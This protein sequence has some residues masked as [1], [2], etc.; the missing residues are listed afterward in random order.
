VTVTAYEPDRRDAAAL[1]TELARAAS[2]SPMHGGAG[3]TW[4]D[5][6]FAAGALRDE[7]E[8]SQTLLRAVAEACAG[9]VDHLDELPTRA[10]R[11][12]LE[13]RLGITRLPIVPDRLV[14]VVTGDPK[15]LPV[16]LRK[17]SRLK[18]GKGPLGD[19]IY[20]TVEDLVVIGTPVV[21]AHTYRVHDTGEDVV[22]R[23]D[24]PLGDAGPAD[25]LGPESESAATHELIVASDLLRLDTGT[26]TITL[27][28]AGIRFERAMPS[29]TTVTRAFL[30][31]LRWEL[32]GAGGYSALGVSSVTALG[33]DGARVLL[34]ATVPS[35]PAPVGSVDRYH[36]RARFP[37][38]AS[39]GFSA[40]QA[41]GFSFTGLSLQMSGS[42]VQPQAGYANEGLL[43][44]TKEFKP[45]GPVPQRGD[46]F[47]LRS[48]E[49]FSK[50]LSS[51]TVTLEAFTTGG[52]FQEVAFL[53]LQDEQLRMVYRQANEY[54]R[55]EGSDV[56]LDESILDS[57]SVDPPKIRWDQYSGGEWHEFKR[58]D[59]LAT[60]TATIGG[61]G[62]F[63][64]PTTVGGAE[65]RLI[66][67]FLWNGDFGWQ[68]YVETLATNAQLAASGH[69]DQIDTS[70]PLVP[71]APP[72][73]SRVRLGY[74]TALRSM[75][76]NPQEVRVF[77]RNALAEPADVTA[78]AT[79]APFQAGPANSSTLYV[80]LD[81]ALPLGEI[82]SLYLDIDA[83]HAC[84]PRDL[85]T[86]VTFEYDAAAGGWTGLDLFDGTLGL[87][88]SGV[89]RFVS[90][91]DWA[92]GSGTVTAAH[93]RWLRARATS[94]NVPER[95]LR[96]Q[97]DAVEAVYRLVPGH[98]Q[99]DA[100]SATP[101]PADAVTGLA[102]AVPGIK[103]MTN[104]KPSYAGRGPELDLAFFARASGIPRHRNK[105]VTAWDVEELVR[106]NFPDVALV[107]CLAHHSAMSEC[108]RGAISIVAVPRS[109]ERLPVPTVQLASSIKSFV[110]ERATP[111]LAP[112]VLCPIYAEVSVRTTLKLVPGAPG[113]DARRLL[114]QA[115]RDFLH[116]LRTTRRKRGFGES[117]YRSELIRFLEGHPLVL[118]VKDG[119]LDFEP[120]HNGLER[121]DVDACRGLIASAA[122]QFLTVEAT[123]E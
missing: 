79:V 57:A 32:S 89:L 108:E 112:V 87:R 98:E 115:L 34:S 38:A 68:T 71:P 31:A 24:G 67:A 66:R 107:R 33:P 36:L 28:F 123:L 102:V 55:A 77:A 114:E 1:V 121:I 88:Q 94:A 50:P 48:D 96:V 40:A 93:G 78:E 120:P 63:S 113:G 4:G 14:G 110:A 73:L 109:E 76:T 86:E 7:R 64:Q 59:D 82:V 72:V 27:T 41:L 83:G 62:P 117:L 15:R 29:A 118:Y 51:L 58:R 69:G 106:S 111:W 101:L 45:Y 60:F 30:N 37:T 23:H 19:R 18:A 91:L 11:D 97:T 13:N 16:T 49:S 2:A 9:V 53:A 54:L 39:S 21:G 8:P 95:V 3:A 100:T 84:D 103:S 26:A 81:E 35:A 104:P 61:T 5:L 85:D 80:G 92:A 116:P 75:R 105:A 6:L 22:A 47:Y 90:P 52:G 17:G 70:T 122:D 46:A 43:D 74:T 10:R 99:D 56:M 42:S 65:G 20:E 119:L 12:F 44:L 25:V